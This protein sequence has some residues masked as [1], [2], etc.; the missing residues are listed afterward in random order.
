MPDETKVQAQA[1]AEAPAKVA[2]AVAATA[3]KVV[4][5]TATVAKRAPIVQGWPGAGRLQSG[6]RTSAAPPPRTT[7]AL[8]P[9]T[10]G[11]HRVVLSTL[12]RGRPESPSRRPG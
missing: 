3:E 2:E 10:L 4:K 5:E 6:I 12:W 9:W 11:G 7:G 1:A 8:R